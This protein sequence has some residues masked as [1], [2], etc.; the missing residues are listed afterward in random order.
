MQV[1]TLNMRK[2]PRLRTYFVALFFFLS[3]FSGY[4]PA[5]QPAAR[6]YQIKAVFLFNFTQ[7]VQW[8]T[9]AFKDPSSPLVIGVLGED[10]FGSILNQTVTGEALENHSLVVERY[11][12]IDDV[13]DCH[14]LFISL[15]DRQDMRRAL[16]KVKTR[17][18]LTVS[19]SEGF[20]RVGGMIRFY[21]EVGRTRLR[22][23]MEPVNESGLVI[24]SKLLRLAEIVPGTNN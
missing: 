9:H 4:S 5:Q 13:K 15:T 3:A 12:S 22:I 11:S 2:G 24:S 19:D 8:P 10:P 14:I 18:I 1:L 23:N 17:P 7:F 16:D 6:E 20:T 21:N